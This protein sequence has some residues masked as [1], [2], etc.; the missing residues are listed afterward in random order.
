MSPE[1]LRE[2]LAP[3]SAGLGAILLVAALVDS[4]IKKG[5]AWL[6]VAFLSAGVVLILLYAVF[7]PDEVRKA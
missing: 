3:L 5:P 6:P 4:S 2:K 7:R 1:E